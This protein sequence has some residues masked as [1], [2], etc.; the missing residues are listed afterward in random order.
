MCDSRQCKR[1]AIYRKIALE[2]AAKIAAKLDSVNGHK[3]DNLWLSCPSDKT[4]EQLKKYEVRV[5]LRS[6]ESLI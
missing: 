5:A 6:V 2:I 3:A 4:V 1:L